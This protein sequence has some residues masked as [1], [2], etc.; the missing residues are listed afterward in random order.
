MVDDGVWVN[1]VMALTGYAW[2][3]EKYSPD[4]DQLREA[5]EDAKDAERGLWAEQTAVAPW[6]WRKDV[7]KL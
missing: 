5:Q 4:E 7:R 6:D 1:K 3:F 2:W